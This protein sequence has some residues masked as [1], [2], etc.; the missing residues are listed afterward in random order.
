[1]HAVLRE[2]YDLK[3]QQWDRL[4]ETIEEKNFT[5][6]RHCNPF[7]SHNAPVFLFDYLVH[8]KTHNCKIENKKRKINEITLRSTIQIKCSPPCL[9]ALAHDASAVLET[10][11]KVLHFAL[12][13]AAS[14]KNTRKTKERKCHNFTAHTLYIHRPVYQTLRHGLKRRHRTS[15]QSQKL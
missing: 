1:M 10:T 9:L 3:P 11:T 5:T 4:S 6:N 12:H 2:V 15:S 13:T 8:H 14:S 7:S